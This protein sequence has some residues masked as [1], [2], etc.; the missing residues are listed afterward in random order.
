MKFFFEPQGIALIGASNNPQKGGFS[1]LYNLQQGFRGFIYPVNPRYSELSGL[2]CYSSVSQV[3]DP[4]DLAI[5]FVPAN[6]VPEIVRQCAL[7]SIPGV[8]VESGGFAETGETGIILQNQ[9][10]Q[11]VQETGIRIWGP[12]CMGVVDAVRRH[13]FSFLTPTVWDFG[14]LPGTVSLIVQ[15]GMLAGGFL[16]DAMTH[17]TMG[18]SKALSIGNKTDVDEC[19]LL[20]YLVDDKDTSV[21]ALYLE[22]ISRGERFLSICRS[23]AKPIV[24]LK[25]GK[26][27]DGARAAQ[28][29]T[30]SMAGD[31]ILA[32]HALA[33]VGVIEAHDFKQMMDISRALSCFP[34]VPAQATGRTAILTF[35]G[36]A[37]IVSADFLNET[38]L[39]VA[40]LSESTHKKL[41]EVFPEWM[42]VSNPIDLWP[43]V[44]K[45]GGQKAYQAAMEA[46]SSDPGID[47]ILMH[48]YSG[49][50]ALNFNMEPMIDLVRNA[51]KTVFAWLLGDR[52]HAMETQ[53]NLQSLGVPVFRELFRSV[54]CI[55]AV[56]R[57]NRWLQRIGKHNQIKKWIPSN[58]PAVKLIQLGHGVLDEYFSKQF[59]KSFGIPVVA[60]NLVDSKEQAVASA[61]NLGFPVVLKGLVQGVVHK[62]EHQ[63]VHMDLKSTDD[64]SDAL[65]RLCRIIGNQDKILIQKQIRG[66]TELIA[67]LIRDPQFG[68]CVMCGIGGVLAE[69]IQDRIFLVAPFSRE[70]ALDAIDRMKSQM[71]LNG[72]RGEPPVKRNVLADILMGIG[73]IGTSFPNIQEMDINPLIVD[74]GFPVAVDAVIVLN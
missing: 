57:R 7:R 45:H 43:A 49:G 22:S 70:E 32:S 71:I 3:P 62:S 73:Q 9:L 25:G 35:S 69:A 42:P 54:E 65:D 39:S 6:L 5:V 1:I 17:G 27:G 20:E 28:S 56:Y 40:S 51:G 21:I 33:Q 4:V 36:G 37:G 15:S 44:E 68:P 2:P 74:N 38:G 48:L 64:V 19:E 18:F 10:K 30:A 23:S 72:F 52:E 55:E 26:S 46:V 13:V 53:R 47:A 61:E 60:E 50:F 34:E 66:K 14:L 11:I 12:N 16:I 41:R 24:V 67:G 63:L 8:I 59:L 31:S 29:H 58:H